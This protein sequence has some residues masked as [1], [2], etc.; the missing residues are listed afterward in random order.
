M[1]TGQGDRVA[2]AQRQVSHVGRQPT[3]VGGVEIAVERIER[4]VNGRRVACAATGVVTATGAT[5]ADD[6]GIVLLHRLAHGLA[7]YRLDSVHIYVH[8]TLLILMYINVSTQ[9]KAPR[10]CSGFR[11]G[12]GEFGREVTHQPPTAHGY[13][14]L[15]E[16]VEHLLALA[17]RVHQTGLAQ[18]AQMVGHSR[19]ADVAHLGH[20][21][22]DA[23]PAATEQAHHALPVLIGHSLGEVY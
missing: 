20:N 19:L 9:K 17:P 16:R 7:V 13:L 22:V 5:A 1:Q 21:V 15:I 8:L 18:N 4:H 2:A 11:D 3:G 6:R 10:L 12:W 23:Q 14:V